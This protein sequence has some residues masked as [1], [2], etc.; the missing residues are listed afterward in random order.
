[1]IWRERFSFGEYWR[2]RTSDVSEVRGL[3]MMIVVGILLVGFFGCLIWADGDVSRKRPKRGTANDH[4]LNVIA[5]PFILIITVLVFSGGY[6][7]ALGRDLA[8]SMPSRFG[9]RL[10][11]PHVVPKIEDGASLR[12]AMVHDVLHERFPRHGR[13]YYLERNRLVQKKFD[14]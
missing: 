11:Y 14:A 13:A 7:W 8:G 1:S 9:S 10:P 3:L 12:F 4:R 2:G 5:Y 6:G